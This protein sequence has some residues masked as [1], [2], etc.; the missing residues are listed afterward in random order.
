LTALIRFSPKQAP[1]RS[2]T[3]VTPAACP[4]RGRVVVRTHSGPVTEENQ[5]VLTPA[6]RDAQFL[7]ASQASALSVAVPSAPSCCPS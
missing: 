7:V 6:T 1:A 3:A 2:I 5:G 4:H